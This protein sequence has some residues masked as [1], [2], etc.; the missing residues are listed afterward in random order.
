M[1]NLN[2]QNAVHSVGADQALVPRD[3]NRPLIFMHI[4]KCAGTSL[5]KC[6][7]EGWQESRVFKLMGPTLYGDFQDYDSFSS[8]VRGWIHETWDNCPEDI[9]YASGHA[10]LR[11]FNHIYPNAQKL[12][13][14]REP[15]TRIMSH[16][17][18]WRTFSETDRNNWGTYAPRLDLAKQDLRIFVNSPELASQVDNVI[19]RMLLYPHPLIPGGD[20]IPPEHDDTLI[21]DAILAIRQFDFVGVVEERGLIFRL[22][23][24]LGRSLVLTSENV[25]R[26]V[27]DNLRH[28]LKEDLSYETW[29]LLVARS[30]LDQC[31]WDHVVENYLKLN[32]RAIQVATIAYAMNR[33]THLMR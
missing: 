7:S 28:P 12:T 11:W 31:V 29:Q 24:W 3:K 20:F 27:P 4:P 6:L 5:D 23:A 2:E 18:Y 33:F 10:G 30:R 21:A 1:S 17:L 13:L 25:A 22:Q 16:W 26:E 15:I 32:P 19:V 14:L 9:D 8:S